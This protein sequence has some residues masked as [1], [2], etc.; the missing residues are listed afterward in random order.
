MATFK[1]FMH[2]AELTVNDKTSS[3][4]MGEI[5]SIMRKY[6][7]SH[8]L[9][10]EKAVSML[11]DLG[12]TYVKLGQLASNQMDI[13]PKAYCDA[14]QALHTQVTPMDFETV[15]TCLN[16]AYGKDWHEVFQ[17]IDE[18]PLGSASIAQVH[19]AWLSDGTVVAVKV[20]RPGIV[21]QMAEDLALMKHAL[22]L[23]EFATTRHEDIMLNLDGFVDELERTTEREVDFTI[24]LKNLV[25]FKKEIADERG[26]TSP[27]PYPEISNEAVLVME[28]VE[29]TEINQVEDL[30][31]QGLDVTA[32][33]K[34][35]ADSYASQVIDKGFFHAD[36]HAG[37]ILVR[38]G[39]IVWIDLG[40]TGSLTAG[41]R[42]HVG[43]VFQAVAT[44]NGYELKEALLGLCTARGE[45]NHGQMLSSMEE[46]INS[47][48]TNRLSDVNVGEVFQEAIE[49][50]RQQNLVM[51]PSFTMIARGFITLEGVISQIAPQISI[52]DVISKHV[53]R[54]ALNPETIKAKVNE[55]A[56]STVE[57]AESMTKIPTEVLHTLDMV[58]RGQ[59]HVGA[60]LSV[61]EDA[62]ATIYVVAGRLVLAIIAAALF[63][64]SSIICTT[65]M[66]PKLL[67]VPL[68]GFIGFVF[69]AALAIYVVVLT[70]K[71]RH[72][73]LNHEKIE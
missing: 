19:K 13:L 39:D 57:S 69:A 36:P 47:Y 7:L 41:E 24:E 18:T 38:D 28:Y 64:G 40:M 30:K 37:N 53:I 12:P 27:T 43:E 21:E 34:R 72:Q 15:S 31:A 29:G 45:I 49:I 48:S 42:N 5:L 70:L 65:S 61:P 3:R 6:K 14:F 16:E 17:S 54:Q 10:P 8:G 22:A 2:V 33:A 60:D 23:A 11:E 67:E 1:E 58:N 25:R 51:N 46:L 68:L 44:Q 4:R 63:M 26:V 55:L 66:E 35:L 32:L 52:V 20:R 62:M 9:T 59:I 71:D 50:L 73:L 56:T